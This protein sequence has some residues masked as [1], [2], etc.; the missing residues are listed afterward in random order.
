MMECTIGGTRRHLRDLSHGLARRG[1]EIEVVAATLREPRMSEDLAAMEAAGMVVH[2]LP[3]VRPIKPLTDAAHALALAP[4]VL[5]RRFDVIHTHSSKAGALGR[6]VGLLL[7]GA[8]RVHTPHTYAASFD[9][10]KGQG[11]ET[12]GPPGL[13]LATERLLGRVTDRLIHVSRGERDQGQALGVIAPSR[14]RV[15][16]NGI[17]PGPFQNPQGGAEL[18]AEFGIPASAPVVGCVGLLN[19]AKGHDVLVD[20]LALLGDDVHVLLVGHGEL[21]QPLRAQAAELGLGERMHITGWRDDV[22]PCHGAMDVF[23]LPSR[24]EGLSYALLEALAAGLPCVSSQVNGS[25][26]V[27]LPG[28]AE[29][30]CGRLV[31]CGDAPALAEALAELLSQHELRKALSV[32]AARRVPE[33]F[34]VEHMIDGTLAVYHDILGTE[35]EQP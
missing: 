28:G 31:P 14:A 15:V 34:T 11:G 29:P 26:E 6:A 10:G 17:D 13:I 16:P 7:S 22:S 23:C 19:D 20:A 32:A 2:R 8:A 35:A 33:A 27:L 21:E 3:M 1:V 9:G 30:D 24:W 25:P 12:P 4:I 18:R 5:D